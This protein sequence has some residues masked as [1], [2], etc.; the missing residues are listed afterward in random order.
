MVNPR[1]RDGL[2]ESSRMGVGCLGHQDAR[3]TRGDKHEDADEGWTA[4]EANQ[5]RVLLGLRPEIFARR[6][7]IHKRTVI[8]WRD[9]DSDPVATLWEDLDIFLL[10]PLDRWCPGLSP[11]S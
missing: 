10:K 8:R 7:K 9:G 6:L 3:V 1:E 11:I 2:P 4:S 5:L